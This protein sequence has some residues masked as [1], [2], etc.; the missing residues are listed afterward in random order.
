MNA[1]MIMKV[2]EMVAEAGIPIVSKLLEGKSKKEASEN[3]ALAKACSNI[4]KDGLG[5]MFNASQVSQADVEMA[6]AYQSNGSIEDIEKK[7]IEM[8]TEGISEDDPK[9][10]KL[11]LRRQQLRE[12]KKESEE[13]AAEYV[14]KKSNNS[15]LQGLGTIIVSG[16]SVPGVYAL[17]KLIN[18]KI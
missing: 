14:R 1:E 13:R 2:A 10:Q 8:L 4:K 16:L 3:E 11:E 9:Y 15:F 12:E 5:N 6:K 17:I 18:K 7:L